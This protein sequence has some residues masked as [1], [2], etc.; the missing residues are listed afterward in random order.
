MFLYLLV[1]QDAH[2]KTITSMTNAGML[3]RALG[4]LFMIE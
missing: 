4:F 3:Y 2:I 1:E